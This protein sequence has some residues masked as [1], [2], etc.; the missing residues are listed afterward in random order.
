MPDE[1]GGKFG[2]VLLNLPKYLAGGKGGRNIAR[3]ET[4][5]L[6]KRVEHNLDAAE[7]GNEEDMSCSNDAGAVLDLEGC[8]RRFL[9]RKVILINN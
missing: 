3:Y 1:L 2:S 7:G 6:S 8:L 9:E 5:A 4:F